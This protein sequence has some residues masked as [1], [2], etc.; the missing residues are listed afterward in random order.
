MAIT[1]LAAVGLA[2]AAAVLLVAR[3]VA[4]GLAAA[5]IT[6]FVAGTFAVLRSSFRLARRR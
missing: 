5:L 4:S 3:Y 6:A 1:G 2:V